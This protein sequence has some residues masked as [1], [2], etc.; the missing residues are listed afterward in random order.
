MM[1]QMDKKQKCRSITNLN[2]AIQDGKTRK[3]Q[4]IKTNGDRIKTYR[5]IKKFLQYIIVDF[6]AES[7]QKNHIDTI[8]KELKQ[9]GW[10]NQ[11]DYIMNSQAHP[12]TTCHFT[13]TM[14]IKI[15]I[16]L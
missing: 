4:V 8:N 12:H 2:E 1:Q 13:L 7:L 11:V 15:I 5:I 3:I 6:W 14:V 16:N 10:Y 9:H